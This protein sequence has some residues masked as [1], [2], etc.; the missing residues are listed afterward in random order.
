MPAISATIMGVGLAVSAYGQWKA[1]RAAKK[2]GE[3]GQAASE[4]AAGILDFNA[5][6]ADVQATQA[7]QRGVIEAGRYRQQVRA[8]VGAQRAAFAG[9]NVDVGSGSAADVQADAAY[10]GEIDALQIQQNAS[11]EAWGYKTEAYNS[12][13]RADVTRKEGAMALAA[14]SAN[15]TA[16]YIGAAGTLVSGAGSLLSRKYGFDR[17]SRLD[18]AAG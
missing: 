7:T 8:V 18:A 2:A 3:A 6:V 5:Q 10:L 11:L 4:S 1:G 15:A 16:Q 14:G 12:R 9:Q 17:A 13:R